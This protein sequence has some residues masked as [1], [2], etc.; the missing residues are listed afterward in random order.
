MRYQHSSFYIG[1]LCL[2]QGITFAEKSRLDQDH[3]AAAGGGFPV[4]VKN[5]GVVGSVTVSGLPQAEDH[6][7]VVRVIRGFLAG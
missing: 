7:L 1:Q 2:S 6:A 4:I 5:A 3:Y